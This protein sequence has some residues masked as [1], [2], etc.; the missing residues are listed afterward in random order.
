MKVEHVASPVQLWVRIL[1]HTPLYR[2][3]T[4]I[5]SHDST[6]G[7]LSLDLA[8]YY[9]SPEKRVLHKNPH[10]GDYCGLRQPT[11][12]CYRVIVLDYSSPLGLYFHHKEKAKVIIKIYDTDT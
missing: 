5:I 8:I 6:L 10:K 1:D 9:S 11:G 4:P 12:E 2:G 7:Q 3:D